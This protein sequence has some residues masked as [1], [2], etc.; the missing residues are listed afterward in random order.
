MGGMMYIHHFL[1]DIGLEYGIPIQELESM[2][3]SSGQLPH[4]R[5][6]VGHMET[7]V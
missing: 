6:V 7:M 4:R 2:I 1:Q 3:L 5:A